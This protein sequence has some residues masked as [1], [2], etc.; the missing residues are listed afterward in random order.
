MFPGF[1]DVGGGL[2]SGV[3]STNDQRFAS[4]FGDFKIGGNDQDLMI[5][6]GVAVV[7]IMLV[8]IVWGRK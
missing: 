1:G 6:A 4:S 5:L 7:S 3:D 8:A 2:T